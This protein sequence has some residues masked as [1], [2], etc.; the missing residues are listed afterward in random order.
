MMR[1]T[2]LVATFLALTLPGKI[3]G[4]ESGSDQISKLLFIHSVEI[5]EEEKPYR[6]DIA[7][8]NENY[9]KA[10]KREAEKVQASGNLENLLAIR[11]EIENVETNGMP[12]SAPFPG[13]ENFRAKYGEAAAA[14]AEKNQ[15]ALQ[16]ILQKHMVELR[17]LKSELTKLGD[18]EAALSVDRH[19]ET[20]SQSLADGSSPGNSR[21]NIGGSLRLATNEVKD[22][23]LFSEILTATTV[24]L[25][26]GIYEL[27]GRIMLGDDKE[28]DQEDRFGHVTVSPGT[29]I[30]GGELFVNNGSVVAEESLF[31]EV[32]LNV[33]LGGELTATDCVFDKGKL[34]KGGA[35]S[36]KYYSAKFTM[37]NCLMNGCFPEPM[38]PRAIGVKLT[39]CTVVDAVLT[40]GEYYETPVEESEH[41]WRM[42]ERCHFIGC[43]VPESFLLM[44]E[45]CVFEDCK[46]VEDIDDVNPEKSARITLYF[47]DPAANAPDGND[48]VTFEVKS[49]SEMRKDFG[50]K[51]QFDFD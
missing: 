24:D 38:K 29:T 42:V 10:L 11:K 12:G 51:I 26:P 18:I 9:L 3:L 14:L 49:A 4:K 33:D 32:D 45:D 22:S 50:S 13:H 17:E 7:L 31:H 48:D 39:E 19:I 20:L 30:K 27:T 43:E 40:P 6:A 36:V 15:A 44:T 21:A 5:E 8:L 47:T 1:T 35:W 25:D 23:P 37:E 41:E 46:F 16:D 34:R 2:C 28:E